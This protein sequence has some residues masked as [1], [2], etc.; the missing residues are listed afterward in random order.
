MLELADSYIWDMI[1][2]QD[3]LLRLCPATLKKNEPTYQLTQSPEVKSRVK[4]IRTS[5][6]LLSYNE[7]MQ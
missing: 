1:I 5:R 7:R 6:R 4:Q 2:L 3:A